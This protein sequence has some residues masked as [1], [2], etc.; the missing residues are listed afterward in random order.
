MMRCTKFTTR[1]ARSCWLERAW[2]MPV[3]SPCTLTFAI[4]GINEIWQCID[5]RIGPF[6]PLD[7]GNY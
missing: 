6:V 5:I 3:F 4:D 2:R 7:H 1:H